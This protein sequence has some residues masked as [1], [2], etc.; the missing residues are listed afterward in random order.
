V[1]KTLLDILAERFPGASKTTLRSI[2]AAKRVYVDGQLVIAAKHPVTVAS[3]V[4]VLDKPKPQLKDTTRETPVPIVYEDDDILVVDKPARL[5]TSS[6]AKDK[7]PTLINLLRAEY[8]DPRRKRILGLIHRLD[9]DVSGLLILSKHPEAFEALKDQFAKKTAQRE[10]RAIV[11]GKPRWKEQSI[12]S[13]LVEMLDGKVKSTTHKYHGQEAVTHYRVLETKKHLS[14]LGLTLE[15]GK[16]HQIR[17]QLAEHGHPI[18]GDLLYHPKGQIAPRM[19]LAAVKL[20]IEHP[21]TGEEQTFEIDLPSDMSAW[22]EE[23]K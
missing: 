11:R 3:A 19:M 12:R 10:Y 23:Q 18:A 5:L 13:K 1:D 21:R 9:A 16:K 14:L 2:I 8:D 7:R 15:T 4:R 6:G 20:T 22:W 17:V